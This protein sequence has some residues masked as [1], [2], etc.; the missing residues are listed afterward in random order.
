MSPTSATPT[1][2]NAAAVDYNS[3]LQWAQYYAANPEQDPYAP[4]GGYAQV[5]AQYMTGYQAYYGG[6]QGY[7]AQ[8][9]AP[10][11]PG[12]AGGAAAPPPPPP[13]EPSYGYSAPPPPPPPPAASPPGGYSS[14]CTSSFLQQLT[15]QIFY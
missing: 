9:P 2:P 4:Y 7:Q 8:S 10:G 5:M 1:D 6:Q 11:A 13:S 15:P 12:A 3:H 14:V